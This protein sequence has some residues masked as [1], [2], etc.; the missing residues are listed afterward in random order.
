MS[1]AGFEF[2]LFASGQ[3]TWMICQTKFTRKTKAKKN[4]VLNIVFYDRAFVILSRT[5][6]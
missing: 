3:I 6:S 2:A 4:K 5:Q 1:R